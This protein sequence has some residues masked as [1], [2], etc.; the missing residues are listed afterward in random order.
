MLISDIFIEN[1]LVNSAVI[2]LSNGETV[3]CHN[4][5]IQCNIMY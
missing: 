1:P 5:T 2:D 4:K 3:R